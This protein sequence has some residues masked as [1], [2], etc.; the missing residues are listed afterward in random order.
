MQHPKIEVRY[1]MTVEEILGEGTV[2]GL[3][4]KDGTTGT[5]GTLDVAAVFI[6]IGLHP[7]TGYLDGRIGLASTGHIPTDD[8]MRTALPGLAAAGAVRA[9]WSG[10]AVGSAGD[11]AAAA[12]AVDGYLRDGS[13]R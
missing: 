11:G 2:S 12:I 10:R 9:H 8:M 6:F 3:T 5:V 4:V 1:G 7:N 13:W